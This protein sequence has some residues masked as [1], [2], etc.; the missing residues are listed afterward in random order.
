MHLFDITPDILIKSITAAL[1]YL[2]VAIILA[3]Q[4]T[5]VILGVG[6]RELK[7]RDV[8]LGLVWPLTLLF[9]LIKGT[10]CALNLSINIAGLVF[11]LYYSRTTLYKIIDKW[12]SGR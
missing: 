9:Y 2:L 5:K 4:E 6:N 10:I 1:I 7:T 11:G 3:Y 8:W 12:S